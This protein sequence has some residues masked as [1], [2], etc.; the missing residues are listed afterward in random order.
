MAEQARRLTIAVSVLLSVTTSHV[1][2]QRTAAATGE[3]EPVARLIQRVGERLHLYHDRV[4]RVACTETIVQQALTRDL[5]PRGTARQFIYELII[6]RDAARPGTRAPEVT[7]ERQ[8]ML[9]DGRPPAIPGPPACTD[10]QPTFS[11]PLMFLLPE[12]RD[13]YRFTAAPASAAAP[14]LVVVD[15]EQI[16]ADPTRVTW[17]GECFTADGGRAAGRIWIDPTTYDVRQLE[18]RL[19]EPFPV[20]LPEGLSQ[21]GI[22]PLMVEQS[23]SIVRFASVAFREPDETFLLPQS[24][25]TVTVIPDASVPRLRT[26]Q[27]FTSFRR[28][29]TGGRVRGVN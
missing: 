12:K 8:V 21:P 11:D 23:Q 6:T 24:I 27:T 9:V 14:G 26:A 7:A 15:F 18:T 3:P 16:Q 13:G 19:A 5:T 29:M 20:K 17:Q 22:P 10:P 28:F 4:T 25:V 2:A 1:L